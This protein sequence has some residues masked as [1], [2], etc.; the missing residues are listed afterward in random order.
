MSLSLRSNIEGSVLFIN[1]DNVKGGKG[2]EGGEAKGGR[3]ARHQMI[4]L[5]IVEN[6]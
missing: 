2:R 6:K 5:E 3:R 4:V 1:H